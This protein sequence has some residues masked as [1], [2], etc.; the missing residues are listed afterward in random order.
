MTPNPLVNGWRSF[1]DPAG[2]LFFTARQWDPS[3]QS[4]AAPSV[5][6]PQG[7]R[8]ESPVPTGW[9]ERKRGRKWM[10]GVEDNENI[11]VWEEILI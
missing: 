10:K 5:I 2:D 9:T 4:N 1:C 7:R 11:I 3:G 8:P 6:A